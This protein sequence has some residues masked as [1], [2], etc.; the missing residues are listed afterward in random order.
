[1]NNQLLP[2]TPSRDRLHTLKL[3]LS[4]FGLSAGLMAIIYFCIGV[5]FFGNSVLVLDL[6][7]QYVY[8]FES[9]HDVI[10]NADASL[11]YS[12]SRTLAR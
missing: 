5:P 3:I 12:W 8:F 6:N 7:G 9:L 1:M 10:Y 11:L 2:S 4:C